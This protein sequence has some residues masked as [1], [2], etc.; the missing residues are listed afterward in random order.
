MCLDRFEH[1]RT[2]SGFV[3][4]LRGP[5]ALDSSDHYSYERGMD[6]AIYQRIL[7]LAD[8]PVA[9]PAKEIATSLGRLFDAPV[10]IGAECG[11]GASLE[12]LS[13]LS[14]AQ[15][16][17][18]DAWKKLRI[19]RRQHV[20]TVVTKNDVPEDGP[21]VVCVD[22]SDQSYAGLETALDLASKLNKP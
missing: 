19:I 15:G 4:P 11:D 17:T 1:E 18:R 9:L 6:A 8:E 21:I 5:S 12:A 10:L 20:D 16:D 14:L 3:R 22:G 7:F 2:V 13:V